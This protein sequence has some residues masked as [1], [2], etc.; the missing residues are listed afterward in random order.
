MKLILTVMVLVLVAT[1]FGQGAYESTYDGAVTFPGAVTFSAAV[2]LGSTLAVTGVT[3]LTGDTDVVGDF[4]A[5][6]VQADDGV[7]ETSF[8]IAVGDTITVVGGVITV[9]KHAV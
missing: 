8:V 1:A 2:T 9:L 6:S 7:D 4:T 3:T 5:G